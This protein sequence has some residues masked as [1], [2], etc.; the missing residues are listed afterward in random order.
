M[1]VFVPLIAAPMASSKPAAAALAFEGFALVLLAMLLW[2]S[3]WKLNRERVVTFLRTGAN[4]PA[5]LF[6]GVSIVSCLLS[7]HKNY[8]IQETMRVGAGVLLYF[9]IAYQF[10]RSEHLSKLVDTLLFLAITASLVGFAQYAMSPAQ[11]A[12][13]LFGDHQLF[14][15]FLMILL[16][17]VAVVAITE[18]KPG[19]QLA[20]QI[21]TVLTIAC[22]LITHT[23]SAWIGAAAG[24]GALAVLAVVVG[25]KK[26]R[27][28]AHKHQIVLP[29]MLMAVAA[30]FF[31]LIWPQTSSIVGRAT[32]LSNVADEAGWT[33]RQQMWQGTIN[34]IKAKPLTGFGTGLYP[35]Y[36]QQFTHLGF[37]TSSKVEG[38]AASTGTDHVIANRPSLG[39][40]AHNF[41][42]QT[43]AELGIPGLLFMVAVPIAFLWGALKRVPNMDAGLRRSLLIGAVGSIVAF[44]ADAAGS[45]SWQLGQVSMFFWLILGLG[46]GC[47]RPQAKSEEVPAPR[48]SAHPARPVTALASAGLLA[49]L[50]IMSLAASPA[51]NYGGGSPTGA[52]VAGTVVSGV[53]VAGIAA[54]QPAVTPGAFRTSK[55]LHFSG[56]DWTVRD[57]GKI[58]NDRWSGSNAW[59]DEQD[60]LHLRVTN[61][62]GQWQGAE[63]QTRDRLSFGRYEFQTTPVTGTQDGNVNLDLFNHATDPSSA[64]GSGMPATHRYV[65]T[66][67]GQRPAPVSI[68]L[69]VSKTLD[70]SQHKEAEMIINRFSFQKGATEVAAP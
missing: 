39:E 56:Y 62:K 28:S 3:D 19:R 43:A 48:R 38:A 23:R 41:Y 31:L 64:I 6:L 14:G 54:A 25:A 53:T 63:V 34:M 33:Y 10:R 65:W 13:G 2:K 45:P 58:G 60:R 51:A 22:L 46:V 36:Q 49:V 18:A 67:D 52:I 40:E 61:V 35:F 69:M 8:S 57:G 21:A 70:A 11:Y 12:V 27:I 59:V 9:V 55:T 1:A 20:A 32:S 47:L 16:P 68:K 30:G 44:A 26:S 42:L 37:P 5:L 7:P 4:L 15:S 17:I 50:P 29:V 66:P 24:M